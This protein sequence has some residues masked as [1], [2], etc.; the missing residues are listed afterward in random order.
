MINQNF[1]QQILSDKASGKNVPA[2]PVRGYG[3]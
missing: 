3:E 2:E 1:S